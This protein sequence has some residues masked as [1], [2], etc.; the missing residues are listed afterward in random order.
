LETQPTSSFRAFSFVPRK[1]GGARQYTYGYRYGQ[2]KLDPIPPI[3]DDAET[4]EPRYVDSERRA[5]VQVSLG[6]HVASAACWHPDLS[7]PCTAIAGARKRFLF[8]PPSI[9]PTILYKFRRFVKDWIRENL[10]A[11]PSDSDVTIDTWLARTNYPDWRKKELRATWE[12]VESIWDPKKARVYFSCKSFVKD[13]VYVSPKHARS[14][15][16]RSDAFKCAVG[17]IFKLIEE[18]VFAYPAFIKHVPMEQRPQYILDMLHSIGAKYMATDYSAFESLF[19]PELMLDCEFQ[20]YEHMTQFLPDGKEFMRLLETVLLGK[21]VCKFRD[22]VATVHGTRMSG[23]MCTSLGN[24]FSNLMFMLFVSQEAGCSNVRGVVEGDDGLF[25]MVGTPPTAEDFAKLGLVI[26]ADL[27]Y[28]LE[29]ASFC[30]MVFDLEE[31]RI[32]TDPRKVLATFGWTSR[33]YTHVRSHKL[34]QLLR[35]KALSLACQYPGCPV[36]S[37][38]AQYGLRVTQ[39]CGRYKRMAF[40]QRDLSTWERDRL[41]SILS[42]RKEAFVPVPVGM[43]S[44]LLVQELYGIDVA[45]QVRIEEYLDSLNDIRPLDNEDISQSMPV[46]WQEF[47]ADYQ[48]VTDRCDPYLCY[49]PSVRWPQLAGFR[50]E[51]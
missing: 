17:P 28:R 5:P 39:N 19:V 7:D 46:S 45:A 10:I 37:S 8:K 22:F 35:C 47:F 6:P 49:P 4:S 50:K 1:L 9:K 29:T 12:E 34:R 32:L 14:I 30:G 44:R 11:L 42:N 40:K 2:L 15:N 18:Q 31:R 26:K 38:L 23:E 25:T 33:Q 16:S 20:L 43:N 27:H 21:N 51:W 48:V 24:G 36:I 3:K 41:S 13:E